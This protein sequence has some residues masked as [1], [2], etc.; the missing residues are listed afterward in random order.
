MQSR[1]GFAYREEGFCLLQREAQRCGL[2]LTDFH[3]LDTML[4][5]QD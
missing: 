3:E 1:S 5:C 2:N 4:R